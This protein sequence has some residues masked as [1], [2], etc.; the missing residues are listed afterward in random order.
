MTE[1]RLLVRPSPALAHSNTATALCGRCFRFI[2]GDRPPFVQIRLLHRVFA[3]LS[4]GISQLAGV[5]SADARGGREPGL[6][7]ILSVVK[8]LETEGE[9]ALNINS[10]DPPKAYEVAIAGFHDIILPLLAKGDPT[11]VE[12]RMK[13]GME[14]GEYRRRLRPSGR[15]TYLSV[16]VDR[17]IA[18][19]PQIR[20]LWLDAIA[21]AE[22][23]RTARDKP[24]TSPYPLQRS[25][26]PRGY[27][28]RSRFDAERRVLGV[29]AGIPLP[30]S[31]PASP[32]LRPQR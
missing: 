1:M 20:P 19:H 30:P 8:G 23:N 16:L 15:F 25:D 6:E 12:S 14:Q 29:A 24:S 22:A 7:D 21:R 18:T 9:Q 10:F 5:W 26:P 13:R 28:E 31:P 2:S 27:V 17:A 4:V 3:S 11:I 32:V